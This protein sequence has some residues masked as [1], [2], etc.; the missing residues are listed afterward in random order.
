MN[1]ASIS[2]LQATMESVSAAIERSP[3]IEN[4]YQNY[5]S[6]CDGSEKRINSHAAEIFSV[7]EAKLDII[8]VSN[9]DKGTTNI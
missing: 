4:D 7:S 1:T 8:K 6:A 5:Q 3:T 9:Q 2:D